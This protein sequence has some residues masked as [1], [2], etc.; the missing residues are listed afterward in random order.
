MKKYFFLLKTITFR[1]IWNFIIL[2]LSYYTSILLKTPIIFGL[3][4]TISIEPTNY[5]NLKCPECPSGQKLLDRE[6]G[7]INLSLTKKLIDE[8]GNSQ[9]SILFYFQGE[10]FLNN[11]LLK[12]VSY[13]RT[14]NLYTITS[15]NG[16]YINNENVEGIIK[17]GLSEI[18]ISLDGT[19]QEVYE[20]Y[21][22]GGNLNK[23]IKSIEL[24]AATKKKLK[25][26]TPFI[27][28]QFLI[29]SANEHQV[30]EIKKIYKRIGANYLALKTTQIYNFE[31][32]NSLIPKN[33]NYSRYKKNKSNKYEIKSKLK[34]RCYR[35]W[36]TTVLCWDG[37]IVPCCFDKDV[38]FPLGNLTEHL[39]ANIWRNKLYKSFRNRILQSRKSQAICLNCTEG[40]NA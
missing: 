3:P 11:E 22:I 14:K 35:L 1:K 37:E 19:T 36:R 7:Y 18:I 29:T 15:T 38:E 25:V 17:S 4:L 33:L 6:R 34:N 26:Q 39:F 10:P 20:K 21:R 2:H 9:I 40:L 16:H 31:N 23:V 28:I 8:I 12:S 24:L 32:G 30:D 13:A 27:T 5:C